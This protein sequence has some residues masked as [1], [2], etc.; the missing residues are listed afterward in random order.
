MCWKKFTTTRDWNSHHRVQHGTKLKC[1]ICSKSY[2][3]PTSYRDHQYTHQDSQFKCQQCNRNFPFLSVIKNHRRAHLTQK[4][5]KCFSGGCKSRSNIPKISTD[6]LGSILARNSS[7]THVV[8][9]HTNHV[10]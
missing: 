6:T 10:S 1:N 7:V 4:L 2:P 5:F 3:S 9:L 8:I